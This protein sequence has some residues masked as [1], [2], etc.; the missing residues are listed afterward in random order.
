MSINYCHIVSDSN[1]GI[2][3]FNLPESN[4]KLKMCGWMVVGDGERGGYYVFA[5]LQISFPKEKPI[6]KYQANEKL[7][8]F[9]LFQHSCWF[10]STEKK[11]YG[12]EHSG[13]SQ[14]LSLPTTAHYPVNFQQIQSN[15]CKGAQKVWG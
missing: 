9:N 5:F 10:S 11:K 1:I 14:V 12:S 4:S 13:A 15:K 6:Y 8:N 2:N 3:M 7:P